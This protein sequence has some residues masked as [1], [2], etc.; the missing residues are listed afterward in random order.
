MQR[1]SNACCKK[2]A[3]HTLR[4]ARPVGCPVRFRGIF[5]SKGN[6]SYPYDDKEF[7]CDDYVEV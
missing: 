7:G 3:G 6:I 4:R 5:F 1:S 2:S